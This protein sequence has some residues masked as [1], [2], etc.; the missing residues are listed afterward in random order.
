MAEIDH[1][2]N[3]TL[4]YIHT[5]P[6]ER[7]PFYIGIGTYQRSRVM[8]KGSRNQLWNRIV[9]KYGKP[10]VDIVGEYED[11]RDAGNLEMFLVASFRAMGAR[12]ANL[13]SG[14]E[15]GY[16]HTD[17][18]KARRS[19]SVRARFAADPEYAKRLSVASRARMADASFS[20]RIRAK[21][22]ETMKDPA[23]RQNFLDAIGAKPVICIETGVEY[24]CARDAARAIGF[25]SSRAICDCAKGMHKSAGGF[26]WRF[27]D[28]SGSTYIV[29][30]RRTSRVICIETG[31][32]Y[33]SLTEA[34]K[35]AGTTVPGIAHCLSGR[36]SRSGGFS[37]ARPV[38][39]LQPPE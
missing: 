29:K 2:S 13:T 37:W 38:D 17:D 10:N 31:I 3:K 20:K 11:R 27:A 25:G 1:T 30:P 15:L 33:K 28:G 22:A 39:V 18:V 16:E 35:A 14:G 8:A 36:K 9:D 21:R 4:V 24:P 23:V 6:G 26:T 5:I 34:A 7:Y 32:T 12:L 19:A